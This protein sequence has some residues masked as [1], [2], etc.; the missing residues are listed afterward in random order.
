MLRAKKIDAE[1]WTAD[2]GTEFKPHVHGFDKRLWC[3]EGSLVFTIGTERISMQPGDALDLPA[4]TMHEAIAGISG[5]V[6][7]E[8]HSDAGHSETV[9]I[10]S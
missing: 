6:C 5:C 7:Y 8:A 1:R 2:P 3:A 10:V 4:N 9:P